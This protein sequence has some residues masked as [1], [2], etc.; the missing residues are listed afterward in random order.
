MLKCIQSEKKVGTAVA[1]RI[2][3]KDHR[4]NRA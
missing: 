1:D 3:K 4:R 2:A